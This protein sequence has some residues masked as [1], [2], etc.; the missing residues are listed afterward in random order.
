MA[1][2]EDSEANGRVSYSLVGGDRLG[3]FSIDART[4]FLTVARALDRETIETYVLEIEARD[5]GVPSLVSTVHVNIRVSDANDNA[6]IFSESNYTAF[7]QVWP[8]SNVV[9]HH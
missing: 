5:S 4:G 9:L 8:Y 6:P 1:S 7:V 3:Q 2:D